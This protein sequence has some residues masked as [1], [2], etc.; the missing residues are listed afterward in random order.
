MS[1][2]LK[3]FTFNKGIPKEKD[4]WRE[5]AKKELAKVEKKKANVI[6]AIVSGYSP[7]DFKDEMEYLKIR[8]IEL[9][10]KLKS[11]DNKKITDKEQIHSIAKIIK[12]ASNEDLKPILKELTNIHIDLEEGTGKIEFK[13]LPLS[14]I[15]FKI[16][17]Q[18]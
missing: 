7:E 3:N 4:S 5:E 6:K 12:S 16:F 14:P 9:Q 13:Y 17:C 8:S 15:R 10:G 11:Q 1:Q 18:R 2:T